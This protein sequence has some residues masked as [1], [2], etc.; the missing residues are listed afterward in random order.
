ML[1]SM[2]I[3]ATDL[4]QY[5]VDK[6]SGQPLAGG[7]ISFYE[8]SSRTTPKPVY[9]LT[10]SPPN[11]TYTALPNS[12]TLSSVGTIV[13]AGGNQVALYYYPYDANGDIQ[14]YYIVVTDAN[15]NPQF[16]RE[17]WPNI[18]AEDDPSINQNNVIINQLSNPQFAQVL[19]NPANPWTISFA[20]AGTYTYAI[21]AD[22][23]LI[24]VAG[25]AGTVTVTRT[26]IAGI[27]GYPSNP[28]YTL[29]VT[30][31]TNVTQLYLRQRLYHNPDVF[32]PGANGEAGCVA[33]NVT[34][35]TGSVITAKYRPSTGTVTTI[36][37]FN[38]TSGLFEEFSETTQLPTADNLNTSDTGYVDIELYL[39]TGSSTT[40][41]LTSVQL[42][43]V[44]NAE[45][46][47][48]TFNQAPVNRQF[49]QLFHYYNPQLQY[50]PIR[51]YLVGWDF[52]L[53]PAQPLGS[54]VAAFGTGANTSNYVWDQTICFQSANSGVSFSRDA[55]S[56]G[57][58]VTGA[59][60]GQFALIQYIDMPIAYQI[61]NQQVSV[62]LS[63]VCNVPAGLSGTIS[64]WYTD[65]AN[66][67]D[68]TA[69]NSL[70]ATLNATGGIATQH[71]TWV[72][73]P[74]NLPEATFTIQESS[75]TNFNDYGFTGWNLAGATAINSATYVAIVVGFAPIA[76]TNTITFNSISVVPGSIP[77]RPAPQTLGEVLFDC[78]RYYET[79]Y[80]MDIAP[81]TSPVHFG[82]LVFPQGS[83]I[84][85]AENNING[86]CDGFYL[87]FRNVKRVDSPTVTL[88]SD[89]TGTAGAV[90]GHLYFNGAIRSESDITVSTYWNAYYLGDKGLGCRPNSNGDMGLV[91]GAGAPATALLGQTWLSAQ[92]VSD[93]RLGV[94]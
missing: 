26:S 70:I 33:F 94:V 56:G 87:P 47:G 5:L 13:D 24:I 28:P 79:S 90:Y 50:K 48:V 53:N 6:A 27:S 11:Y 81:G 18:T 65:D 4:N 15:G 66:L 60:T 77:T 37:I 59:A 92:Y 68:I 34:L 84:K 3:T 71:G 63:A 41:T 9:E 54:S 91:Y 46:T 67:P 43:G 22:W 1:N 10:G 35:A 62:N 21:A 7:I 8:D 45:V 52:P 85:D 36:G 69:Q 38:N 32:S 55:H 31:G 88:Y 86:L 82:A 19:F 42:I 64:L 12:L 51:S 75:T 83:T 78:Q 49:D 61:L 93:A 76:S 20:G 57:L 72:E 17:A 30:A 89:Q 23:S 44:D 80:P 40:T 16:T 58:V 74:R 2:Y 25:G 14:L 29:S 39:G 73:I